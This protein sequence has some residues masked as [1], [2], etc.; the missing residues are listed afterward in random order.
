[1]AG[2]RKHGVRMLLGLALALALLGHAARFYEIPLVSLLDAFLYD[3]RLRLTMPRTVDARVVIADIDEKSLA[4]LGRWPWRRDRIAQLLDRLF[5]DYRV[6]AVGFD[7]FFVEPDHSSGLPALEALAEGALRDNAAYRA[8]LPGLRAELDH[9]R[10]LAHAL[11]GRPVVLGYYF[12]HPSAG[13]GHAAGRLP[14]PVLPAGTFARHRLAIPVW[15]GFGA[16]LPVLQEAAAL[17]GHVNALVDFDGVSRRVALLAEYEGQYYES[18][19]LAMVRELLGKPPLRPGYAGSGDYAG[20]EWLELPLDGAALR[21]PVDEAAAALIPFRGPQGSFP[22]V[23]IADVL[24]G[25]VDREVLRDRIVLVGTTTPGLLDLRVT[26]V[27]QAFPGVEIH[28]SLISGM[29]D[30]SLRQKPAYALGFEVLQVTLVAALLAVSLP[31]CGPWVATLLAGGLLAAT[32]ALNVLAWQNGLALPLAATWL[33]ILLLF[34]LNM[35]WGYFVESRSKRRFATLFGQYVPPPLVD[36]MAR[37][38]ERYSMAGRSA[39]LSVLFADVRGFTAIAEGLSPRDLAQWMNEYLG[40][41]TAVIQA[42]RGTLD[43]YVGDLVMAFWGAPVADPAHARRAVLAA[44]DMQAAVRALAAPFRAK[45][46]PELRIG[47]GINTGMMT[48]GDMG[49][50]VRKAYTVLGDAVNLA[51][52]LEGLTRYYD[53]GILVGEAT[54]LQCPDIVFREVDRVRVKGKEAPVAIHEPLGLASALGAARQ[55]ELRLW[56]QTLRAFRAADWDA[57]D[58]GLYNLQRLAPDDG[59]YACYAARVAH[60]RTRPPGDGWDGVTT[61]ETK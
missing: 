4:E 39:E 35:S 12:S 9:D 27:G 20:L 11:R 41:M 45:G 5:D 32:A 16:N 54:R 57:A 1:M 18:L 8:A 26:P 24:A 56:Q 47:V 14:E 52:R 19:S 10:R 28:A 58:V 22:Y 34:A 2:L 61:F 30:G 17:S 46:W 31:L 37:D 53:V 13:A 6:A 60:Y 23:S 33:A 44:L 43:K 59:L 48:V 51:S 36:E 38:P 42:Q 21:I 40:A 15:S 55:E 50:A 25:R 49:S 7:V 29:L 3:A